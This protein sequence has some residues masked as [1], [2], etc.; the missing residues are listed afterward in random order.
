MYN[1]TVVALCHTI[2]IA[3]ALMYKQDYTVVLGGGVSY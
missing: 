1:V 2:I 3:S